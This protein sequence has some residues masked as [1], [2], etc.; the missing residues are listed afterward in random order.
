MSNKQLSS[1]IGTEDPGGEVAGQELRAGPRT[2]QRSSRW[3]GRRQRDAWLL[4]AVL[5]LGIVTIVALGNGSAQPSGQARVE[6]PG[7]PPASGTLAQSTTPS[8]TRATGDFREYL[9]PQS[10]SE[11]MRPA[12]DHEGRL[13]FGEMGRNF[14]AVFDPQTQTFRQMTPPGGR[15]GVMSVQVAPDDTI[16]FA[17]EYANYIGHYFPTTGRYQLY[18]LPMLTVPDPAHAGKTLSL[19]SAPNELALDAHGTVWFTEF[20]A[21][22]LGRLDPQTGRMQHYL[23]SAKRSVQTLDPYGVTVDQ[24]GMVWFTESSNDHI[25]RLD[26]RTGRIRFFTPPGPITSLMEIASDGRG[27]IW[28]T[29]FSV[30]LVLSLDPHTGTFTRYYAPST[31]SGVGGVYGLVVTPNGEIWVTVL[32]DNVIARLDPAAHRFLP[33]AIP[34][35]GSMPLGLVMGANH[36][37]WFTEVDKIGMFRP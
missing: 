8:A 9:L 37:F 30:G 16:W 6:L 36:T 2:R 5:L 27:I 32:V 15:F 22:M 19:P 35:A 23:L 18:Q 34:T 4:L 28:A 12:I 20:N 26:P 7:T 25:G 24:K 3:S 11:V 13:W 17:E 21:D 29:S 33:Y 10:N 31:G 14:L 1:H